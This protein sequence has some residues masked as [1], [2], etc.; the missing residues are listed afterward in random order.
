VA[1]EF[2][3]HP[4]NGVGAAHV[5]ATVGKKA[6]STSGLGLRNAVGLDGGSNA[7]AI[8]RGNAINGDI[9]QALPSAFAISNH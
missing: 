5:Y 7:V 9:G 6:S 1:A 2:L 3:R 8:Y 4:P